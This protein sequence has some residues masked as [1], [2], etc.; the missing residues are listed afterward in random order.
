MEYT[1]SI[2]K[3]FRRKIWSKFV[4]AVK[5]YELIN[6]G[7]KIAVCISGGK[8]SFLLALCLS[9]LKRHGQFKFDL[10]FIC[11]NPGYK[12]ENMDKI[13]ENS[14]KLGIDLKVFKSNIFDIVHKEGGESPCYLCARM[15]RGFLYSKAQELG[16]NKIALGHHFNDV[17]E[18]VLLNIFYTGRFGGMPPKLRS[19][20]YQ[21]MEL[22]RPLYFVKEEDIISFS[23]YNNLEFI[24]CAC[25]ITQKKND[26]KR[27]FVKELISELVKKDK[28]I[29]INI[30]RSLENIN[31]N[32][33]N[34]YIKDSVKLSFNDLYKK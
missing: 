11:M 33:V 32:T 29:D 20:N 6:E 8:D 7:D 21:D 27:K 30:F 18:T 28:N 34:G 24:D 19:D 5:E 23:H 16:C 25:A 17:I 10:E 31:L 26:S 22:I 14:K 12:K 3:K 13:I 1:K 9:E 2:I 4:R 15:R